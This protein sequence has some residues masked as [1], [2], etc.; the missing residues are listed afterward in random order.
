M[1]RPSPGLLARFN[2]P[3]GGRVRRQR[4]VGDQSG[5]PFN[6]K[7]EAMRSG[8]QVGDRSRAQGGGHERDWRDRGR[9]IVDSQGNLIVEEE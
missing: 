2:V 5:H 7:M 4:A 1:E 3:V 8:S 9:Q 6:G